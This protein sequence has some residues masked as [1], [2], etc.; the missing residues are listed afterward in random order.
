MRREGMRGGERREGMRREGMRGGERGR[1]EEERSE[2][3]EIKGGRG[4]RR[5]GGSREGTME[6]AER[7]CRG[8]LSGRSGDKILRLWSFFYILGN[9]YYI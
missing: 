5:E 1:G 3:V 4:K 7:G 8:G 9:Y 2:R 6:D